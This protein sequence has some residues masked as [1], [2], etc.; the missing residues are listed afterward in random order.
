MDEQGG[1][2]KT[3]TQKGS[4]QRVEAGTGNLQEM[5]RQNLNMQKCS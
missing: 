2:G 5:Q 4:M 1:A 3:Q